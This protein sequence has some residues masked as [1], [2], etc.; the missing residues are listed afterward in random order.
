MSIISNLIG[1]KLTG[2]NGEEFMNKVIK[3]S[4]YNL[5]AL[6]TRIKGINKRTL[7]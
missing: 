1:K 2:M 4:D 3:P 5:R 7:S 6:K